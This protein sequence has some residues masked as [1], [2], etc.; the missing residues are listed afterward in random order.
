[1][2]TCFFCRNSVYK[3]SLALC[4]FLSHRRPTFIPNTKYLNIKTQ[5][6]KFKLWKLCALEKDGQFCK[7]TSNILSQFLSHVNHLYFVVIEEH[8]QN[9]LLYPPKKSVRRK[10][11]KWIFSTVWSKTELHFQPIVLMFCCCFCWYAE[12]LAER[13][14]RRERARETDTLST[15]RA[16]LLLKNYNMFSIESVHVANKSP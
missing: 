5:I 4:V 10:C 13:G 3:H 12:D 14:R 9:L 6:G 7:L 8:E 1:M 11:A 16:P 15:K 2:C